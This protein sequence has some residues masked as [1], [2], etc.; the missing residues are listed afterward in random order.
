MGVLKTLSDSDIKE[1]VRLYSE[2]KV[3]LSKIK[4]QYGISDKR[5]KQ[6]LEDHN[7]HIRSHRESRLTYEYNENYF[8]A[9]DTPDKAYWLGFIYADGFITKRT[10]GN[11]VFGIT[12][13]EKE[14]L[15]KI[16][17]CMNSNKPIG[18][19]KKINSYSNK[20]IEYKLAFCSP[21]L[22][23]DLEKWGCVENKTFKLKFPDFLDKSLIPHFVRGYFD[24]DGSVFY[25]ITKGDNGKEYM[26][27]GI[28]ICGIESY[29]KDFAKACNFPENVVY[30]DK[31]KKTDCWSIKLA[32][33][34]RCLTMY[35][36]MYKNAGDCYLSRKREKFED[37]IKERGSTTT[38]DNLNRE[39][40]AEYL[41]LCY[42]ED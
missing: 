25:H 21:Q 34:I 39:N 18:E 26:N 38:I 16:N 13:A 6:I 8:N 10:H 40:K 9:I 3:S 36:F 35:H 1:I 27:L 19:Y 23:S 12:L 37:F 14:P 31:R 2:E 17:K 41:Q 28:T 11:P 33:N 5:L 29:L 24:G 4:K 20:S 42:L 32:S 22:T 7:I 15:E 30:K